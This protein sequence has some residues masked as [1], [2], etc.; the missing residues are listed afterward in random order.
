VDVEVAPL[1]AKE[2]LDRQD[3]NQDSHGNFR[4]LLDRIRQVA[5]EKDNR[6]TEGEERSGVPK[7]PG[8]T[9]QHGSAGP[10][11]PLSQK[12]CGYGREVIRIRR[13]PDAQ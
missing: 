6:E 2:E 11:L 7:P 5:A 3:G 13:M 12:Q 4:S 9:E 8:K 1:P 10:T